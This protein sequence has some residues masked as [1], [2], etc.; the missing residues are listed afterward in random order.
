MWL[1]ECYRDH[2]SCPKPGSKFMP[3]RLL[4]ITVA[5]GGK[6]VRVVETTSRE[7]Q[8]YA[9]LSY[10]WGGDQKVKTTRHNLEQMKSGIDLD[11]LPATLRDAI[12]VTMGL[13]MRFL[14]VDALCIIQDDEHDKALEIAAMPNIYSSAAVAIAASRAAS[15]EDGFLAKRPR[16][17]EIYPR[18]FIDMRFRLGDGKVESLPL[19]N[20]YPSTPIEPLETR[21]W[22]FQERI[23]S[24][25]MLD[26]GTLTT[27]WICK[28]ARYLRERLDGWHRIDQAKY[29]S[30][31]A[32][33]PLSGAISTSHRVKTRVDSSNI[34]SQW[35]RLLKLYSSRNLTF[36]TDRLLAMSGIA[37][38][39]AIL[40]GDEYLAGIWR[41]SLARDILWQVDRPLPRSYEYSAP[42]WSWAAISGK[43]TV[44]LEGTVDANFQVIGCN[45]THA[46]A[47]AQFGSVRSGR[48]QLRGL[49]RREGISFP[50]DGSGG[51]DKYVMEDMSGDEHTIFIYAN[52]DH[53]EGKG[54]V[55]NSDRVKENHEAASTEALVLLLVNIHPCQM[56][57]LLRECGNGEYVRLGV[58][59]ISSPPRYGDWSDEP[60]S[61]EQFAGRS[62]AFPDNKVEDLVVV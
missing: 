18:T 22:A 45:V 4:E 49:V 28:S 6:S 17:G 12:Q 8:P 38:R 20:P 40:L 58:F 61:E 50:S 16:F 7:E 34:R 43:V 24:P 35:H 51:L 44:R 19:M 13:D 62:W 2:E 31:E 14:W 26:Y 15:V 52:I 60:Y 23:L 10:C 9:I 39:Y 11:S 1:E 36:Q 21:G 59:E 37:E 33:L 3:T 55:T 5:G 29:P 48:L 46:F 27:E 30:M 42:S 41:S 32:E 54:P 25:R 57:L 53:N 47:E 56:G